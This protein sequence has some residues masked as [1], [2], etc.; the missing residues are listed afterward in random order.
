MRC[1]HVGASMSS[2][3]ESPL[4][5]GG[6][7]GRFTDVA[8]REL[9]RYFRLDRSSCRELVAIKNGRLIVVTRIACLSSALSGDRKSVV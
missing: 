9:K 1:A 7:G 6:V 4:W 2:G 8:L 5:K 3:N